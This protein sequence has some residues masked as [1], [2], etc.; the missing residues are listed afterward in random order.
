MVL[1]STK[2][3]FCIPKY[4]FVDYFT[5]VFASNRYRGYEWWNYRVFILQAYQTSEEL[6]RIS[7]RETVWQSPAN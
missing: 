7:Y 4:Q 5:L 1:V 3:S 6:L 2:L